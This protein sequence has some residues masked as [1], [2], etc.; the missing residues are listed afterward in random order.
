MAETILVADVGLDSRLAG[1]DAVYTYRALPGTRVGAAHFVPLGPRKS[2][3]YVVAL[4][5]VGA[6]DLA[7]PVSQ[8][9]N[10]GEPV[11]GLDLPTELIGV[12]HEV[13]RQTLSPLSVCLVPA[14]PPGVRDRLA[15]EYR[16]ACENAPDGLTVAQQEVVNVLASGPIRETKAKPV[17]KGTKSSLRALVRRDIVQSFPI[18]V[19]FAP[20]KSATETLRLTPD[21]GAVENFL[22][23]PG[24]KRPAQAVT[25]MRLQGSE[26][27]SFTAQEIKALGQVSDATV[28]AL[29]EA[30]LLVRTTAQTEPAQLPPTPNAAQQAAIDQVAEAVLAREPKDFL[31]YG[32]TGSGKTEVYLRA[33]E[34]AL[35][36]GRQVL[37]LVPEIALTAQVIAQLR[38]RF[39]H[40]VAVLHSN[41]SPGERMDSWLRVRSGDAPV[42]LG[43]R[44]ALFAPLS[45]LGLI[46]MDE[47]HEASYKQESAPRYHAK[48]VARCLGQA[49]NCPPV[50]GSAT[51]S[52]ETFH[53]ARNGQVTLLQLPTRAAA[54]AVLPTIEI[55]NLT[56]SY[57][58]RIASVFAPKLS[59]AI[60]QTIDRGEQ[61]ILFLNRRAFAPFVVCRDCA[62]RFLCPKCAVSLALHRRENKLRCHHCGH[63]EPVPLVC[64]ECESDKVN[65]FGVGA[66]KVEQTVTEQFS[67]A[68]V[69]RLD[70]DIARK[71]GA[72][73]ETLAR[74]RSGELNVLVGTQMV[75]KGLDFPNVTLVGVIA[76]DISLNIPDF[77]AS[78]RTFQLLTQ[79][80][81]RA[82]RGEKPGRVI[83]QTLSADHPS[84]VATQTHDYE[85]L[86]EAIIR[87]RKKA[88]YPPFVQIINVLFH[89]PDRESVFA[90]S[91]V[92]GQKLAVGLPHSEVLGPVD[93]AIERLNNQWRRHLV[94]KLPIGVDYSVILEI[95]KGVETPKT[96][97]VID[98]DP[99]SM[100]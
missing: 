33:A 70:R 53:E 79:V 44:S 34:V 93:C 98:V 73:E 23:G 67:G 28:A 14:T 26:S 32:I 63:L 87:E 27:A 94:V 83:I 30:G 1:S 96:R 2:L 71:K 25:L 38:A 29:T 8:L 60:Q 72:L 9:R 11:M 16:L 97:M 100:V 35:K 82:G 3:G 52:V 84:I 13:S 15:T 5:E 66:E 31:L 86:F 74:F 7:F 56:E 21:H 36:Q 19:P 49:F 68:K 43:P 10:L 62:H 65:S 69:A 89:G 54:K 85:G 50:L 51:P 46:V 39:G 75:A 18:I 91:A 88:E 81:G 6:D 80:A 17:P 76:A 78:E 22:A 59:T 47:E 20:K 99:Y 4:R 45:N 40:K 77:R 92:V 42:V 37:Y 64:P 90:L 55:E 61:T 95:V 57:K 48:R 58:D 12:V 41:M 24:K